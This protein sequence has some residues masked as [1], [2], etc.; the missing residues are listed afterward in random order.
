MPDRYALEAIATKLDPSV[1]RASMM[2]GIE[3]RELEQLIREDKEG[4]DH[5]VNVNCRGNIH[6]CSN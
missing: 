5:P 1:F 2:M 6:K 4:I 3:P